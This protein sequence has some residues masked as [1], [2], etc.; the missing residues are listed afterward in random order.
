MILFQRA[1]ALE[2]GAT[3][4]GLTQC[5]SKTIAETLILLAGSA[6][7]PLRVFF[8]V[9]RGTT[10]M[11]TFRL[12]CLRATLRSLKPQIH[13]N[14]ATVLSTLRALCRPMKSAEMIDFRGT[15]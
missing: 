10:A 6:S 2:N 4:Y 11:L 9:H 1:R 13:V 12:C 3:G 8:A 5:T 14:C 7:N 15:R